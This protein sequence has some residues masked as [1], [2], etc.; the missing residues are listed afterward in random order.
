M[1][2]NN[3]TPL[4]IIGSSRSDGNTRIAVERVI[5]GRN[6]EIADLSQ[7]DISHYDYD[8]TNHDDDFLPLAEKMV[9]CDPIILATPVY[10]YTMSARMK[11]FIDRWTDLITIR[12]DLGRA[13]KGKKV[14][15]VTSFGGEY[16]EGFENPI[17]LTCEYLDM[18]FCGFYPHYSGE[19]EG[20]L[21]ENDSLLQNFIGKI[22]PDQ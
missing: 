21:K 2:S 20:K 3:K 12:K 16:P 22:W 14:Y 17:R 7:L 5:S 6:S 1:P 19:D 11:I 4:V 15:L 13:M 9:E 10:W 18:Q 8:N